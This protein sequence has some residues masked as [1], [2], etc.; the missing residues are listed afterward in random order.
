MK[1]IILTRNVLFAI[2]CFQFAACHKSKNDGT[3]APAPEWNYENTGL[4]GTYTGDSECNGNA[5]SPINILTAQARKVRLDTFII[6][7]VPCT[8]IVKDNGHTIQ[9]VPDATAGNYIL[10][11]GVKSMVQQFHFH[12]TSEHK[13][14]GDS[15]DMELHIVHQDSAGTDLEVL[16]VLLKKDPAGNDNPFIGQLW[17]A[18][19]A[20]KNTQTTGQGTINIA[21]ALPANKTDYFQYTGSLTTPPCSQGVDWIVYRNPVLLSAAQIATFQ[22]LYANNHRPVKPLNHRTVVE[23]Y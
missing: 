8:W 9:V 10:I 11:N 6:H 22:R 13:I 20:Q 23:N 14:D 17:S 15:T 12:A 19:P 16:G 1:K 2:L 21:D 5:E 4:W 3:V 7:Y 18:L